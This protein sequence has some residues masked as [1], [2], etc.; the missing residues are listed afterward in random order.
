MIEFDRTIEY[1][2]NDLY[3]AAFL[4]TVGCKKTRCIYEKSVFYFVFDNKKQTIN[5]LQKDYF[6][7][8]SRVEPLAYKNALK[9]LRTEMNF[10]R[11]S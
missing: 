10:L 7:R 3:F 6:S 1:C 5:T 11:K 4:L 2:T 8:D 9:D